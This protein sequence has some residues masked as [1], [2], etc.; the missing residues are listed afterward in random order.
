MCAPWAESP[1]MLLTSA[2]YP[3]DDDAQRRKRLIDE[4]PVRPE[5]SV[6]PCSRTLINCIWPAPRWTMASVKDA[7]QP[8]NHSINCRISGLHPRWL[9]QTWDR[10]RFVRFVWL[11]P[12]CCCGWIGKL[13]SNSIVIPCAYKFDWAKASN[14]FG[15]S[16]S[17]HKIA[18]K[19]FQLCTPHF[20]FRVLFFVF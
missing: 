9:R 12:T 19:S 11:W 13:I 18:H 10:A 7:C 5:I 14:C 16:H 8:V 6:A 15:S 4:V 2:F 20:F 3:L 1:M 17:K